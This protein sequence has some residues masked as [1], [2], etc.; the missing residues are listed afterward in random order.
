MNDVLSK[1]C[2]RCDQQQPAELFCRNGRGGLQSWCKPCKAQN[3]REHYERRKG[4]PRIRIPLDLHPPGMRICTQCRTAKALDEF[5]P[6]R[7]SLFGRASRCR[8]CIRLKWGPGAVRQRD[9][10]PWGDVKKDERLRRLYGISLA[11]YRR[12]IAEQG[13]TCALCPD[14]PMHV[15]HHHVSGEPRGILCMTDNVGIGSFREELPRM[16]RAQVYLAWHNSDWVGLR[17]AAGIL[18]DALATHDA[19]ALV[20][21]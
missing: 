13:G 6:S 14:E 18:L 9:G 3:G 8:A 5:T 7:T 19:E 21:S 4:R 12:M 10:M 2:T 15:D 1:R 20:A 17:E 11:T 16:A